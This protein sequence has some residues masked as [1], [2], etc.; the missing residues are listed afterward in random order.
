MWKWIGV[1]WCLAG[2]VVAADYYVN[3]TSGN[4]AQ[5]GTQA[6]PWRSLSRVNAQTLEPGDRILL[7]RGTAFVGHL[8]IA[9]SGTE[10]KPIVVSAYGEGPAPKLMNPRF[11]LEFGRVVSVYG[12]YV[13]VENLYLYDGA[14]PP[15]DEPP[16]PWKES[17]QHKLVT[18]MAGIYTD[19]TTHHVTLQNN[20]FNNMPVGVRVRGA[21]SLVK[22]NYFHDASRITEYWGAMAIVIVGPHNE[23]AHNRIE[24]YGFY[25]GAYVNDG[26]AVELD[27]EDRFFDAHHTF[28]HHNLSRNTKGGFLEI[29]GNTHDVTIANNISDDVDKFVG[30]NGIRNLKIDGNI[31]VRTRIP[32]ITDKDF[33]SLRAIFWSICWNGCAGDR[34]AGVSITNNIFYLTAPHRIY[35]APD[36][37]HGFMSAKRSG[38]LYWSPDG[39]AAAMLGQPLGAGEAIA[40]PGFK[41]LLNGEYGRQTQ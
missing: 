29:A 22:G 41:D 35:L 6:Q 24:N 15:P 16:L 20:E 30:T 12:S 27:G 37:P 7:A 8:T 11:G 9:Q 38:N 2:P 31:I 10:A 1:L 33:W 4:D 40:D 23:V 39:D 5:P 3:G 26:A 19:A 14:T 18:D 34:D 13:T 36:N 32:D 28:V 17:H 25:G 21:N